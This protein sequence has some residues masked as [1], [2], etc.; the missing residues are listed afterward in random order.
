MEMQRILVV[1]ALLFV[2]SLPLWAADYYVATN[3]SDTANAG[4][5]V[6][7]PFRTIQRAADAVAPGDTVHI[8]GGTYREMITATNYGLPGKPV[9]FCAYKDEEPV[10]KG[11]DVVGGWNHLTNAIWCKTN[12][13]VTQQV[14]DDGESLQMI[15]PLVN[16]R[17]LYDRPVGTNRDDMVPGSFFFDPNTTALCVWLADASNP[18]DSVIE[19]STRRY[20][21]NGNN[22]NSNSWFCLKGLHFMHSNTTNFLRGRSAVIAGG[23]GIV[24][25]CLIEW[26]HF[27]GL[28]LG[29]DSLAL[30][31]VLRHNGNKGGAMARGSTFRS[32]LFASNNYRHFSHDG[33]AGGIKNFAHPGTVE[34]CEFGWND[35]PGVWFDMCNTGEPL[36]IRNNYFH[37]NS[38]AVLIE[39]S[40]GARIW[41]NLFEDNLGR[42]IL[43][44]SSQ[45]NTIWNNTFAGG[46]ERYA[47]QMF[48]SGARSNHLGRPF[49][50]RYNRFYNNIIYDS[51]FRDIAMN[52]PDGTNVL[53]NLCDYN[54]Y[55][56]LQAPPA[57]AR[58]NPDGSSELITGLSNWTAST[59][60][61]SNSLA[62]DPGFA[63]SANGDYHLG[64]ASPCVDRGGRLDWMIEREDVDGDPRPWRGQADI[65]FD[66]RVVKM[67]LPT[68]DASGMLLSCNGVQTGKA[69]TLAVTPSLTDP[70]WS[71]VAPAVTARTSVIQFLDT[72]AIRRRAFYRI[73]EPDTPGGG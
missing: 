27:T 10:I 4:T 42:D 60:L 24:D 1:T 49:P 57:F 67:Q 66:E 73:T 9:T 26:T 33:S 48:Y 64:F 31:C 58:V 20:I 29:P 40:S 3:G 69:Y 28:S 63:D 5:S 65:G 56:R 46:V 13:V 12:W 71:N 53:D 61:E 55:Y 43:L 14:F 41:N 11:S 59:G 34:H 68:K 15:G 52:M 6:A 36:V 16:F 23:H 25:D 38:N 44:A 72:N 47:V 2:V 50:C 45:S 8:R 30:N 21:F 54:C 17:E 7:A 62:I 32:C 70:A 39:I 37:H 18:N 22:A 19:V 35:G 51:P